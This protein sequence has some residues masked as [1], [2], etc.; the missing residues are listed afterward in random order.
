MF[1]AYIRGAGIA[2]VAALGLLTAGCEIIGDVELFAR[3]VNAAQPWKRPKV[4]AI[5]GTN[6]LTINA[7]GAL[8]NEFGRTGVTPTSDA[9]S[10]VGAARWPP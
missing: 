7:T 2:S 1:N 8:E 3:T 5:T 10:V 4:C 9:I 6:D